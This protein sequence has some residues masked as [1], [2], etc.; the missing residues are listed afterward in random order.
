MNKNRMFVS[1]RPE[2]ENW[3]EKVKDIDSCVRENNNEEYS[4][5]DE[6]NNLL[7]FQVSEVV[8]FVILNERISPTMD[9]PS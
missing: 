5:I 1:F 4:S 8:R 2:K 3:R 9:V 6:E 7:F